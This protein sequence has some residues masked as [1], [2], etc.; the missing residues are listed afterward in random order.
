VT[1]S[2]AIDRLGVGRKIVVLE[3]R[4]QGSRSDPGD[5]RPDIFRGFANSPFKQPR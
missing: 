3:G 5:C 4:I 2:G 1:T